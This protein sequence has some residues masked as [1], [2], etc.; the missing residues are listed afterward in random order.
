MSF[1][2]II[3]LIT[4]LENKIVSNNTTLSQEERREIMHARNELVRFSEQDPM[5]IAAEMRGVDPQNVCEKCGGSGVHVYSSTATWMGGIGGQA[6]TMDVC[7]GCWGSGDKNRKGAD[8]REVLR[9][10]RNL[11]DIGKI[12]TT[13][14]S[15]E[16]KI[17][18]IE[19]I[20]R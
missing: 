13:D 12:L 4:H 18:S 15:A 20:Y 2:S 16:D 14:A 1:E 9:D 7:D 10:K 17:K 11:L 5:V 6:M 19:R 8:L 3:G